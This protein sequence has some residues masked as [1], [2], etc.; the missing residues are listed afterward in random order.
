MFLVVQLRVCIKWCDRVHESVLTSGVCLHA[1][2]CIWNAWDLLSVLFRSC[3]DVVALLTLGGA[4]PTR[5]YTLS[6]DVE[7]TLP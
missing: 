2:D 5:R 4:I 3:R 7:R 6:T 1:R